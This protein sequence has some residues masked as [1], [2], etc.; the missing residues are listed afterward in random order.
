MRSANIIRNVQSLKALEKSCTFPPFLLPSGLS[1]HSV[2]VQ[3]SYKLSAIKHN[4]EL[5]RQSW[6]WLVVVVIWCACAMQNR[7]WILTVNAG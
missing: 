3:V 5:S 4:T 7:V 2:L 1:P 6:L